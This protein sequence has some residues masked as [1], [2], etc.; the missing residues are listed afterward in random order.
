VLEAVPI[1][2]VILRAGALPSA[3][4]ETPDDEPA[5]DETMIVRIEPGAVAT[6]VGVKAFA[7]DRS[8]AAGAGTREDT[9]AGTARA[10]VA[11]RGG[12]GAP[13]ADPP[14]VEAMGRVGVA[15]RAGEVAPDVVD[16]GS[17]GRNSVSPAPAGRTEATGPDGLTMGLAGVAVRAGAADLPGTKPDRDDAPGAF[18]AE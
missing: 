16:L 6:L 9:T 10:G 7:N 11:V 2:G 17:A 13:V 12:A 3:P 4:A 8:G 15:I 5:G 18:P 1:A 14:G